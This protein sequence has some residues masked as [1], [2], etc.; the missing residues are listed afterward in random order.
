GRR[1]GLA[2][3]MARLMAARLPEPGHDWLVVP[4]PLHRWRI[5]RRGFNQAAMLAQDI[6][7]I[8]GHQLLV[9][10][11]TRSKPTPTLGGLGRKARSRT[12]AGAITV[13]PMRAAQLRGRD[14]ILVD[15]V[16]T[17]GATSKACVKALKRAGAR[18]VVIGC[19]AR[20]TRQLDASRN[21][22]PKTVVPGHDPGHRRD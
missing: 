19:F 7:Q 3:T 14:V 10:G 5:W 1:I 16:L 2:A 20:V 8:R 11:L 12:L 13:N 6:S 21:G 4:V 15:D 9:D 17:T 18:R 22:E